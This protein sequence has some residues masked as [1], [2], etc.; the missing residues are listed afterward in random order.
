MKIRLKNTL[1][2]I[3]QDRKKRTGTNPRLFLFHN[4]QNIHTGKTYKMI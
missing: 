4:I 2:K 3:I 1:K